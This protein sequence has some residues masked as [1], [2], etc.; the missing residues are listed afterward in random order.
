MRRQAL[1]FPCSKRGDRSISQEEK[2]LSPKPW[3]PRLAARAENRISDKENLPFRKMKNSLV[4]SPEIPW[5]AA[6]AENL[7]SDKED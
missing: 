1:F 4:K 6:R 3:N 7:V 2:N 5:L